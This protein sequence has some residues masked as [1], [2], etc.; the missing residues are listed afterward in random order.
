MRF[1]CYFLVNKH[2]LCQVLTLNLAV[3]L[4]CFYFLPEFSLM[5]L[6][7]VCVLTKLKCRIEKKKR[8]DGFTSNR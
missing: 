3:F 6:V 1:V 7:K 2:F 4:K 5:F 8:V